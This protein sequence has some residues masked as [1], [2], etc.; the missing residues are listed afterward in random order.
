VEQGRLDPGALITKV[1]PFEDAAEAMTEDAI[2]I[3]FA[4]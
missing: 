1:L 4:R 2:K 3:V